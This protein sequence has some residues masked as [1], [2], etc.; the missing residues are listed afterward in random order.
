M[1]SHHRPE[2]RRTEFSQRS[3]HRNSGR[4]AWPLAS[5]QA[6]ENPSSGLDDVERAARFGHNLNTFRVVSDH[7]QGQSSSQPIQ[8]KRR[9]KKFIDKKNA[10]FHG[11]LQDF[12]AIGGNME[13]ISSMK[14]KG[15]RLVN[16]EGYSVPELR[17][18]L[19]NY[20]REAF[21]ESGRHA[22]PRV[23]ERIA[24]QLERSEYKKVHRFARKD[25]AEDL[26]SPLGKFWTGK[27]KP[28]F[29]ESGPWRKGKTG[30]LLERAGRHMAGSTEKSPFTSTAENVESLL[31]HGDSWVSSI[32][33]GAG[34]PQK[35]ASHIGSF[36]VPRRSLYTPEDVR[37]SMIKQNLGM[38][39]ARSKLETEALYHGD[40]LGRY[41]ESWR[42]NP[43]TPKDMTRYQRGSEEEEY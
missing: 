20:G 38:D 13:G 5:D 3:T 36:K 6:P 12:H 37:D 42:K 39:H 34:D 31:T 26:Y 32:A 11:S 21:G 43:Y 40:D 8:A 22:G 18:G 4:V 33:F 19:K 16:K 30:L 17:K 35:R 25:H 1:R 9:K 15:R 2:R 27:G 14:E 29:R 23:A 41:L 7:F 10:L 24:D 28:E